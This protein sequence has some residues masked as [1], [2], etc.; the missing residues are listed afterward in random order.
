MIL[1]YSGTINC[2]LCVN[3]IIMKGRCNSSSGEESRDYIDDMI[4]DK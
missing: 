4:N 1:E 2:L 3:I